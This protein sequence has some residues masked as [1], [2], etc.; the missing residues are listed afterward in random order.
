MLQIGWTLRKEMQILPLTPF[1]LMSLFVN[2][3][4]WKNTEPCEN[5]FLFNVMLCC[6]INIFECYQKYDPFWLFLR[7]HKHCPSLRI[8]V[9]NDILPLFPNFIFFSVL[10]PPS[11]QFFTS[12]LITLQGHNGCPSFFRSIISASS[13]PLW[14]GC[15]GLPHYL[16]V[17]PGE[18]QQRRYF[19][20][21]AFEAYL[22]WSGS[23]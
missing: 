6:Q 11:D 1:S 14:T 16:S 3:F 5:I 9:F 19:Q 4:E 8:M 23:M 2:V 21:C 18:Q 13:V 7:E 22:H 12:L 10:F 17:S 20:Q 15:V